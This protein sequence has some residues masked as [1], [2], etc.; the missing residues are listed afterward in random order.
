MSI[1]DKI[2]KDIVINF[3]YISQISIKLAYPHLKIYFNFYEYLINYLKRHGIKHFNFPGYKKII[4]YGE[5]LIKILNGDILNEDDV[6]NIVINDKHYRRFTYNYLTN[7]FKVLPYNKM[8]KLKKKNKNFNYYYTNKVY[9]EITKYKKKLYID[10]I[11]DIIMNRFKY[12]NLSDNIGTREIYRNHINP[13]FLDINKFTKNKIFD[14]NLC[15]L[16]IN[17]A[18]IY[19]AYT[20][21]NKIEKYY[22]VYYFLDFETFKII[23]ILERIK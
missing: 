23:K 2:G 10:N 16:H 3:P 1:F 6:F 9:F 4:F 20:Y 12:K 17:D 5:S 15:L 11:R 7:R 8:D 21:Y 13:Y 19:D 22:K 18:H 14:N